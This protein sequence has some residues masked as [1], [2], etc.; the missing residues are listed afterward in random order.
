MCADSLYI[1]LEL[2]SERLQAWNPTKCPLLPE[3]AT[4]EDACEYINIRNTS[5]QERQKFMGI[6][7]E[8]RTHKQIIQKG[9]TKYRTKNNTTKLHAE[10]MGKIR[11]YGTDNRKQM[12]IQIITTYTI[13][14][15][16]NGK[17]NT[18]TKNTMHTCHQNQRTHKIAYNVTKNLKTYKNYLNTQTYKTQ[19][20]HVTTNQ[21]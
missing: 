18:Y 19:I 8:N 11:I 5:S 10:N 14:S 20:K 15:S 13:A 9:K 17:K 21:T 12:E 2:K 3:S 6:P 7:T 4:R 16:T 1:H